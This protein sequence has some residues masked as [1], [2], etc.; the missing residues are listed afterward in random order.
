MKETI[1]NGITFKGFASII[2]FVL[3]IAGLLMLFSGNHYIFSL[4]L[5]IAGIILSLSI[6]GVIIDFDQAKIKPYFN[7]L[8][9]KTGTWKP[10]G[11]YDRIV[12]ALFNE[13]QTMNMISITNT[14]TVKSFDVYLQGV[15]EKDLLVKEFS[16][17][18]R[19]KSFLDQYSI[20][21][22]KEKVDNYE[23]LLAGINERQ[24]RRD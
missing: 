4:L 1:S 12:L 16:E 3:I 15:N 10:L 23:I 20:K 11:N 5:L 9:Y 14:Y 8:V 13:S 24:Q 6:R 22:G 17:Y 2:G 7:L 18:P 19:A 21:L